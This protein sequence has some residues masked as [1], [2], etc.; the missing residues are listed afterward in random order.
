MFSIFKN[1]NLCGKIYLFCGII[2]WVIKLFFLIL[3]LLFILFFVGVIGYFF[4][5]AFV[6]KETVDL[7][8][9][10]SPI[11]AKLKP[12]EKI[13]NEGYDFIDSKPCDWHYITSFDGLK[14]AAR[15]F[16][17]NSERTIILFHGYRSS[18]NHDFSCAVK[19]Y[20]DF[21][22]NILLVDQ[23]SHGRSEGKLITFGVKESKDVHTWVDYINAKFS[24]KEIILSGIS[25]GAT[26]VLLSLKEKM[27]NNVKCVL[28]DCGFTSPVDIIK[29]VAKQ[30]FKLNANFY[31]PFLDFACKLFGKFSIRNISTIDTV[32]NSEIP[33]LFIHGKKDNF[34]PCEMSVEAHKSCGKNGRII[35]S[36]EADHGISFLVDTE[37]VVIEIYKFLK[38]N[39]E[40]FRI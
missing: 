3:V 33:I 39:L 15:Y 29:K 34:V 7:E 23:R 14:L 10:N 40:N 22:F 18:A 37:I 25:M 8:D 5:L 30:A 32:S 2:V 4:T 31:I 13:L 26:T 35:I 11:N 16:E 20:Y 6:R 28:A 1:K 36:N 38:E 17:N 21:G 12:Y 19:L 27:P 9:M 24:P